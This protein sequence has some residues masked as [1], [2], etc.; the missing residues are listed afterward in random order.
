M[1]LASKSKN[2]H[3]AISIFSALLKHLMA[4]EDE[5]LM[6]DLL[7]KNAIPFDDQG[8]QM[9]VYLHKILDRL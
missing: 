4:N 7:Q 1:V 3:S 2:N 8:Q 5:T 6:T 9:Y